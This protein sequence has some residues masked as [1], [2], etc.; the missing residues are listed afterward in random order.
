MSSEVRDVEDCLHLR[1]QESSGLCRLINSVTL[2]L[3]ILFHPVSGAFFVLVAYRIM[4]VM[5]CLLN[6]LSV[7][8]YHVRK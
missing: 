3:I 4:Q 5:L 1:V 2:L 6:M 7:L 8:A